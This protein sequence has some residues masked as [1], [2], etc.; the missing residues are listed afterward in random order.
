[1]YN[2]PDNMDGSDLI[3][4]VLVTGGVG[5][6]GSHLV[7]AL[8]Q[9]EGI[10]TVVVID[11]L[12][13]SDRSN[14]DWIKSSKLI[15]SQGDVQDYGLTSLLINRYNIST[16]FH[17]AT[18]PLVFSIRDPQ[19]ATSNIIEMQQT[20][21]ECQR[22]KFFNRLITFS[23]S[24]V[25]GSGEGRISKESDRL[26][27]QTPYAAAKAACDLL[28]ESYGRSFGLDFSIV[29]PFNNY[30]PRKQVFWGRAGI[31]PST[32]NS[33][34]NGEEVSVYGDGSFCRDFVF[35]E[36][37][38]RAALKVLESDNC[39]GQTINVASGEPHS[40]LSIVK[41]VAELMGRKPK[42][43]FLAP[44]PG[45]LAYLRGDNSKAKK[46]IG[47]ST[48][49]KWRTGLQECINYYSKT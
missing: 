44:R 25:Y 42:I 6:I 28:T 2:L 40:V 3:K 5:F 34:A 16:V 13:M 12:S 41:D 22:Q 35:V 18:S 37:T 1:M 8:V 9:K 11:N 15:F 4:N 46:L 33:L 43:K 7:K 30:G 48:K 47:F 17:L 32:I 23:T 14:L 38:V 49:T 21:L 45:D 20:L 29:R 24:E 10:R 39:H 36:D 31:I 27:P 26:A 19:I